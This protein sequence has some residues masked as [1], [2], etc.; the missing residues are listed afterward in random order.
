MSAVSMLARRRLVRGPDGLDA[1]ARQ[2]A[3]PRRILHEV[4]RIFVHPAIKKALCE[5]ASQDRS[6]LRKI[7][8]WWGHH[9]HF[10]VRLKCPSGYAGCK[11]Q[12]A[13]TGRR[14]LW[15]PSGLLVQTAHRAAEAGQ[16]RKE[17]APLTLADLPAACRRWLAGTP[18]GAPEGPVP[19]PERRSDLARAGRE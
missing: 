10:H 8:P 18:L 19:V 5:G 16:A 6:W 7:R 4:A 15:Q 1:G 14:W 9:Y 13:A 12:S 17:K 3:A 2:T 11:N